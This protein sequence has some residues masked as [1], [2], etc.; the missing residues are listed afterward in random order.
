MDL[1][2]D[3]W[4]ELPFDIRI[5]ME[6]RAVEDALALQNPGVTEE[7]ISL[8]DPGASEPHDTLVY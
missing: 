1:G 3:Q 7:D 5:A 4:S 6:E 8:H 2:D